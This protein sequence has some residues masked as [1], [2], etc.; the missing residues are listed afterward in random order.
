MFR[1]WLGF[2][3]LYG[4]MD[5]KGEPGSGQELVPTVTIHAIFAF[6]I[7]IFSS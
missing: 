5:E 2:L 1:G 7:Y 3:G 4:G 6:Q